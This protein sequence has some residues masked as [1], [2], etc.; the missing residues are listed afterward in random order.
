MVFVLSLCLA[1]MHVCMFTVGCTHFVLSY[2]NILGLASLHILL[3]RLQLCF[4]TILFLYDEMSLD[5]KTVLLVS[6]I[7][8]PGCCIDRVFVLSPVSIAR[9]CCVVWLLLWWDD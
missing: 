4:V 3:L 2:Y 5:Y 8:E 9:S 6:S 7:D 1:H